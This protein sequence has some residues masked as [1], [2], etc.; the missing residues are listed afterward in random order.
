[1]KIRSGQSPT[2]LSDASQWRVLWHALLAC[3]IPL[4]VRNRWPGLRGLISISLAHFLPVWAYRL[5]LTYR[6][7][8]V[9]WL[10]A[11]RHRIRMR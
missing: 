9:G 5:E 6:G 7:R 3:L 11:V 2:D 4:G 8:L 1:M 10:R